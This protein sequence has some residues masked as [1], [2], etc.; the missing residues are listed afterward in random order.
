MPLAEGTTMRL[1]DC[2]VE[3]VAY[4]SD[5]L[6]TAVDEN[7]DASAVE[8]DYALLFKRSEDKMKEGKFEYEAWDSARFALCAWVDEMIMCSS[9]EGHSAWGHRQLQRIYYSS[10]NAGEEFFE[11]LEELDPETKDIREV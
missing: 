10:T 8:Q 9:W 3:I 4:T 6:K 7:P 1:I 11:R 2:F 5:F